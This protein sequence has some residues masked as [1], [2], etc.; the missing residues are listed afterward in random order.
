MNQLTGM[1]FSAILV[2][3]GLEGLFGTT[4]SPKDEYFRIPFPHHNHWAALRII[5]RLN[6]A[7]GR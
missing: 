7:L 6:F 1:R 5:S 2:G 4:Q 3:T